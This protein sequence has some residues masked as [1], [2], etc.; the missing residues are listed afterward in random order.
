L[1]FTW[2]VRRVGFLAALAW[3]FANAL[4][5]LLHRYYLHLD[6]CRVG[7]RRE[8]RAARLGPLT[9]HSG[10]G[11][12]AVKLT[13]NA[14]TAELPLLLWSD[15]SQCPSWE[16]RAGFYALFATLRRVNLVPKVKARST[17]Y[18]DACIGDFGILMVYEASEIAIFRCL[19]FA[20]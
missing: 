2:L 12:G 15:R 17:G 14:I 8:V 11:R 1:A 4:L 9:G 16:L 19:P 7:E 3:C 18:R 20:F 5:V 10:T 6:L 13:G